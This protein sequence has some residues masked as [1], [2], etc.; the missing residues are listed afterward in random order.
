MGSKH[1]VQNEHDDDKCDR[2]SD[3]KWYWIRGKIKLKKPCKVVVTIVFKSIL[4]IC[5]LKFTD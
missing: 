1:S 2:I 4:Q 5:W 3:K